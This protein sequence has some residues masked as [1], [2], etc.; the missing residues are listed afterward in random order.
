MQ[1]SLEFASSN[2]PHLRASFS[3][4][5]REGRRFLKWYTQKQVFPKETE[6]NWGG[7]L[8]IS[9]HKSLLNKYGE[10]SMSPGQ[11]RGCENIK[12]NRICGL[13]VGIINNFVEEIR[14]LHR[15]Q[16]AKRQNGCLLVEMFLYYHNVFRSNIKVY[17]EFFYLELSSKINLKNLKYNHKPLRLS[18]A[19]FPNNFPISSQFERPWAHSI[20]HLI[21]STFSDSTNMYGAISIVWVPGLQE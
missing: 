17:I 6:R 20:E 13:H 8:I 9:L 7:R 18:K 21:S 3:I 15:G 1:F 19:L 5:S 10:A 14:L 2:R 4:H 12:R 16:R 11:N